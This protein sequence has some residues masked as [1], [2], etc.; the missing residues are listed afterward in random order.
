MDKSSKFLLTIVLLFLLCIIGASAGGLT[1][2]VKLLEQSYVDPNYNA[3]LNK[4]SDQEGYCL[5]DLVDEYDITF[6]SISD[7][8]K[9]ACVSVVASIEGSENAYLGSG[10]C[11][12]SKDYETESGEKIDDGSYIVTNHH[13]FEECYQDPKFQLHVYPNDY[14]NVQRYGVLNYYEAEILWTDSYLDMAIIYINENIDWVRMKDRTIMCSDEDMLKAEENLFAIGT[15]QS[16]SYQNTV[17]KGH[18]A[19]ETITYTYTIQDGEYINEVLDNVYEY[20]IPINISIMGGNSGGGLF[21]SEGFLIGQPTLGVQ[22]SQDVDAINY[23]IPIYT[24]IQVLDDL[25][26]SNEDALSEIKIY[27]LNDLNFKTIDIY[28]S[29]IMQTQFTGLKRS[30]YGEY[31]TLEDLTYNENGLKIIS[32]L[33]SKLKKGDIIIGAQLNEKTTEINCRNDL[34]FV[35]LKARQGDTITFDLLEKDDVSLVLA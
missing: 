20:L 25:I 18:M 33:N 21:D 8:Y 9:E 2:V 29:E 4:T 30:F 31:Y 15:P 5:T 13:V 17:T 12:A 19:S 32:S 34:I 14:L 1:Y 28:E 26:I 23:S 16:L 10:V 24:A 3:V 35:L 11:I 22:D 7:L 6:S 27:G